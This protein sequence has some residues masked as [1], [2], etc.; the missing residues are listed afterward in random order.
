MV[1]MTTAVTIH[2]RLTSE[3]IESVVAGLPVQ[4]R[5]MIRLLLLQYLEV[6]QED[7]RFIAEDQPDSRF[8]AGGQ[9]LKKQHA[10]A[11][12]VE[13]T[14]RVA[15]YSMFF[16]QKRERPWLQIEC[17]KKQTAL[18]DLTITAAEG[19][20]TSRFHVEPSV[21][22]TYRDNAMSALLKPE[23]RRLERTWEQEAIAADD[24]QQQ[25][26]LI[27]YQALLRRRAKQRRRL[28]NATREFER[29]GLA[30]LQDHEV[31]HIWGIPMGSLSAR[32][33]KAL[34]HY[35]T[36]L[37]TKLEQDQGPSEPPHGYQD[38]WQETIRVLS[39]KPCQRSVVSFI[40]G[41]ERTEE[42]LLEKL[43]MFADGSM[44]E[45]VESNFWQLITR[46]HDSEHSGPWN[47]HVRAIFALQRL[48]A[49]QSDSE[50]TLDEL[51]EMLLKTTKPKSK[52]EDL[53]AHQPDESSLELS[54]Q[55]LGVLNAFA[56]EIDDKRTH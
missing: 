15:Q 23:I 21:V 29:S 18:T 47:N 34:T 45:A 41:I 9:P 48:F 53:P 19:L 39:K 46:I 10:T 7:C 38:L 6:S 33:V 26:L 44:P 36:A 24:Y 35:L 12:V 50:P 16:R 30:P 40:P 55:A 5:V 3:C 14:N 13:I 11:A 27:A 17:L 22:R 8:L 4:S 56:G 37:Q 43:T 31:A 28:D 2:H 52:D 32:K 1:L 51:E 49:I 42:I 54:E 20:I 25:R